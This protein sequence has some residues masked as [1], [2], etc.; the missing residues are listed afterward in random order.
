MFHV[1]KCKYHST[2]TKFYCFQIQKL[3][4][5]YNEDG[6]IYG[7]AFVTMNCMEFCFVT[8]N[9]LNVQ[10]YVQ[11]VTQYQEDSEKYNKKNK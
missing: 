2:F 1:A 5:L 3:F 6:P 9:S 10:F 8:G 4:S 7:A 11:E